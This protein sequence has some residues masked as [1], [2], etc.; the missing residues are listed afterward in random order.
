[1]SRISS[2]RLG[3]DIWIGR[4]DTRQTHYKQRKETG[5]KLYSDEWASHVSGR[6]RW[7]K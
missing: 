5:T 6:I 2:K 3:L 1:M 4:E 7:Q